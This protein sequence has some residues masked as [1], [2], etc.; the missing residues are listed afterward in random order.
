MQECINC[1]IV[2]IGL[3]ERKKQDTRRAIAAAARALAE[4]RGVDGFTVDDIAERAD[5]STRTVFN[6]FATKEAAIIGVDDQ[7]IRQFG[8]RLLA[9][10]AREAPLVALRNALFESDADLPALAQSWMARLS[11]IER[12]PALMPRPLAAIHLV[13]QELIEAMATRLGKDPGEDPYPTVVV[14]AWLSTFRAVLA[15]WWDNGRPGSLPALIDDSVRVL[16]SEL[17]PARSAR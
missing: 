2:P 10:P 3:R 1:R 5:V 9:R 11:L 15:W 17:P 13:E 14:A 6:H 4:E 16:T 7:A 12:F 8:A